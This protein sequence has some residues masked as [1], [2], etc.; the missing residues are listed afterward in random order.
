[1][2]INEKQHVLIFHQTS[3]GNEQIHSEFQIRSKN[4]TET[5][6]RMKVLGQPDKSRT[7]RDSFFR[8]GSKDRAGTD[9]REVFD[10]DTTEVTLRDFED[11]QRR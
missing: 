8:R 7:Q 5:E 4:Y 1:M 9:G 11:L 2:E 10:I 3:D 6:I